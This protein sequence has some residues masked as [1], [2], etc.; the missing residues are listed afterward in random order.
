MHDKPTRQLAA[1][2]FADMF[3]YTA[4]MQEDEEQARAQ[5]ARHRA[6]MAAAV[7][8]HGGKVLQHYGDG[9]LSVFPS[10]VEAVS[11]ALEV[12]LV[13]ADESLIPLRIGVHSGD[14]VY[15]GDDVYG[16]GVNVA[17]RIEGLAAP[18]GVMLSGKVYD[19][20]KNHASISAI[21]MGSVRLKNVSYPVAVFALSNEGLNVPAPEEVQEKAWGGGAE[22]GTV[23]YGH[24]SPDSGA[25]A[26][27]PRSHVLGRIKDRALVQ[28]SLAYIASAWVL[29]ELTG[30]VS[31]QFLWPA[32]VPRTVSL[33]A[34]AGFFVTLVLAWYHGEKGRQRVTPAELLIITVILAL[35]GGALAWFAPSEA[36][37][38]PPELEIV[39]ADERGRPSIAVLPFVSMSM[40]RIEGQDE[41]AFLSMGLHDELLTQLSKIASIDVISRTSVMQYAESAKTIPAIG[42]ELGVGTVLEG[43]LMQAGGQV[44]LNVQLIDVVTNTHLWADVYDRAL[45]LESIF[46]IQSDLARQVV[47]ALHTR[48]APA[49]EARIDEIPT[50]NTAAYTFYRRG[51]N[52]LDRPGTEPFDLDTATVMLSA[53]VVEDPEFA[54][55]YAWL[56]I[57]HSYTYLYYDRSPERLAAA[58]DAATE[59]GR[60][61]S[62]LPEAHFARAFDHY[63]RYENDEATAALQLAEEGLP[64]SGDLLTLKGE[65][66]LRSRDWDGSLATRE[67]G[68]LLDPLNPEVAMGLAQAYA[69]RDRWEEANALFDDILN[70]HPD[71]HQA[72]F[73]RGWL[74]WRRTGDPGPGLEALSNVPPDA[75]VYGLRNFFAWLLSPTDQ[76]RIE[77]LERIEAQYLEFAGFWW[78]PRELLEA[79]TYVRVDPARAERAFT[80]AVEICLAALEEQPGDPRIHA[81]LGRAYGGLGLREEGVRE[82]RRVVDILPMTVDPVFGR[83]LMEFAALIYADL[84]M[85][86]EAAAALEMQFSVPG[87]HPMNALVG[88]DFALV[89]DHP[90]LSFP[91]RSG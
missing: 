21:P 27:T 2:M 15:H 7:E 63:L 68:A 47:T 55:A 3:G 31:D 57:S 90:R 52:A 30:F 5:T 89:R 73:S 62:D 58:R 4:L 69:E 14:L 64:G 83:D 6:Y 76:E 87:V 17:S 88:H 51:K 70:R 34:L 59:A 26:P 24:P 75:N 79:W 11:C 71:F 39:S 29:L 46:A 54:L 40:E 43:S 85:A 82:A 8:E 48:L 44:R 45:T 78:A 86:E 66:L 42:R 33:L 36:I 49:E 50:E 22:A 1:I 80:Q 81:S 91:K 9:T 25:S 20:I 10:A 56:S 18:G 12:Q 28:W 77:A 53:A 19:E 84:G 41:A 13:L 37:S 74:W 72:A 60:H 65:L 35:S 32:V 16:D 23:G 38:T 67:R 61:D